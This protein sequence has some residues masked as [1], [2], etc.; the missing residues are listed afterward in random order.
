MSGT[1]ELHSQISAGDSEAIASGVIMKQSGVAI[2]R[3]ESANYHGTNVT[4]VAA[5]LAGKR[6]FAR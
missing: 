5:A 2:E 4:R 1:L 6:L 3:L